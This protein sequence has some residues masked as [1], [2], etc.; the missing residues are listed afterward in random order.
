MAVVGDAYIVVR[1]ITNQVKDD[2]RRG[3][4]GAD[5]I[6]GNAG[7]KAGN[8]F[9]K[10]FS[11][12]M[13]RGG[14]RGGMFSNLM[15]EADQAGQ[16]LNS[17]I[18]VG[19]ALGPAIAGLVS[20]IGAA[21]GGLFALGAQAAAAG[22]ALLSLLNV[23]SALA[24]GAAVLKVAFSGI[25][26][27]LKA[28][29]KSSGGAARDNA[30]QIEAAWDRIQDARKR[31]TQVIQQNNERLEQASERI[32]E[33]IEREEAAYKEIGQAKLDY[34]D[35]EADV[36][37]A[38]QETTKAREDAIESIQQL[39]FELEEAVLS[40]Q[41][42][43]LN[44]EDAREA[45]AKVQNLPPNN[46]A[47]RE[48]ELAFA[49]ADLA[50]RRAKDNNLDTQKEVED[51]NS[52]GV[53]GSDQVVAALEREAAAQKNKTKAQ[54]AI[55]ARE[56]DYKKAL[57][58]TAKARR[59]L[60]KVQQEN[61]AR[62]AEAREA[63]EKARE[64]WRD[65]KNGAAGAAG[66]VD[67]FAE[68]MKKLSP[69]AQ[70]FVRDLLEMKPALTEIKML[71]QDSFFGVI[72][73]DVKDL[74]KVWLPELKKLL[75][76]TG[77][78]LGEVGEKL[79]GVFK[80]PENV[81][82]LK[83]IWE[84]NDKVIAS[85]GGA[86]ANLAETFIDLMEAAAPLAEEF[87]DWIETITSGW[88][89]T[90]K[91]NKES[92]KLSETLE[93]AGGVAKTLGDIFGNLFGAIGN[94][95]KAA[96]GPGSGGEMLLNLLRDVTEKWK[97]FTGSEEGQARL[98]KFFQ[99]IVPVVS[100][101]GGLLADIAGAFFN[102]AEASANAEGGDPTAKFVGS[103][104]NVVGILEEMGTQMTGV[105]PTIGEGLEFA[106]TAVNN[107]TSSGA[108]ETFFDVLK[109]FAEFAAGLTGNPIFQSI[110]AVVAPVFALSRGLALVL[111]FSKFLFLGAIVSKI[112]T[113]VGI[114]WQVRAAIQT[115]GLLFGVG[116]GP[117]LIFIAAIAGLVAI[118]V[119]MWNESETF[120]ES[121]KKLIDGVIQK[122]ITIFETLK[123]KLDEAL[124]PLGGTTG[125]VDKLRAAFKWLGDIL[126]K[127]VIPFF[128]AGLKNALDIIGA[129]LG[130]L[131]DWIGNLIDAFMKIFTGIK[132][133]DIKMIFEGIVGFII[134]PFEALW[135]NLVDLV[136]NIFNN[137]VEAVK[138]VLGIASPSQVFTDIATSIF[139]AIIN[140]ITFLPSK[141]LEFFTTMWTN[142]STFFTET[143][144]PALLKWPKE[145]A[146]WIKGIWDKFFGFLEDIWDKI[147][148]FYGPNGT[149]ARFLKGLPKSIANWLVG[150]WDAAFDFLED[151][152]DKIVGFFGYDSEIG[153]FI[154]GLKNTITNW[155]SSMWD[156]LTSGLT[157]AVG[158]IK[159]GLRPVASI[160]NKLIDGANWV[161]E[162][163]PG[164]PAFVIPRIPEFADGG[165]VFPKSGGVLARVAEA[166]K[167]ERIEPLDPNG[168]SKR[169]K[170]MIDMLTGD[171]R[172]GGGNNTTINVYPSEGMD[173]RELAQMVSRE[174]AF[175][176]RRGTL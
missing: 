110:F 106:A 83:G 135:T 41:R 96:S 70:G 18:T 127:Y 130:T 74:S 71:T 5:R 122:A 117:V 101:V 45:L 142:V 124:E 154:R 78:V 99:N 100:E 136:K 164:D 94:I 166:G 128:E 145:I 21:A 38:Q 47:R 1:A 152:Y 37:K 33:S 162:A 155:A 14:G 58:D 76:G 87:A 90:T 73:D 105:L 160:L 139:D 138:N 8:S 104:R 147:V 51:A 15:A 168:L 119:A 79:I 140:V 7:D 126:G 115:V 173:E 42:A 13:G 25:G 3:F 29:G 28:S 61:I 165:T 112:K 26:A 82:Q 131:I 137:V 171:A 132:T 123:K 80:S 44:F 67:Q 134:A 53:E 129:I 31:V 108:I 23:F 107:L 92:G 84:S 48:A 9:S 72:R 49:E 120:R 156:G 111:K 161:A 159:A 141:F 55:T 103:L 35:A 97:E 86:I 19:Y 158:A 66:G 151:V 149:V 43:V 36:V 175:M 34:A 46:R 39:R 150:L 62:E 121:I 169:D 157:A 148:A 109:R 63:L 172:S 144:G 32:L 102:V 125:L 174:L 116:S 52:K 89:E 30:K 20:V 6:G 56:E 75:P 16:K 91:A 24:Q 167:P 113:F 17:L 40:E 11:K 153:K 50:L 10:N 114:F 88:R 170:A 4:D 54:D 64:A 2:I 68:A 95:G 59:E 69:E 60:A 65:A 57:D 118:F 143:I 98:T 176:M 77:K 22:P 163:L 146:K 81:E 93:Y 85:L 133:G 12:S 27:A